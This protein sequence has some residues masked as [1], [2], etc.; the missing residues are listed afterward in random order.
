MLNNKG[1]KNILNGK[2][3]IISTLNDVSVNTINII[4]DNDS[5][6]RK[7]SIMTVLEKLESQ[8]SV[9]NRLI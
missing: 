5:S 9:Y 8:R 6:P 3:D 4:S 1:F 7:S 2:C